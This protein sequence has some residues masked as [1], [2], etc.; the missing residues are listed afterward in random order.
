MHV[1]IYRPSKTATQSG[2]GNGKRWLLEYAPIEPRRA[3]PLMGW[4]SSGDTRRQLR[5]YFE[6]EAEAEAYARKTGLS[7]EIIQ[8]QERSIRPKA[9]ADNFRYDRVGRWTH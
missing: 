3:D 7:Y 4:T 1:R 8:P 2:T 9:Y 6:S 5:L